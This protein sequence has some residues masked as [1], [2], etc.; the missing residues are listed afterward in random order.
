M[1]AE[2]SSGDR[3]EFGH[4]RR[5]GAS[6]RRH[7]WDV[8]GVARR[9]ERLRALAAETGADVFAADL[10]DQAQVDALRDHVAEPRLVHALVNVAGGAFGAA[11][12][13]ESDPADW[14]A[15][16]D[17]NVIAT[18]RMITAML[19]LLRNT[20]RDESQ[21]IQAIVTARSAVTLRT[22]TFSR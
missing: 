4:R 16:F 2:K 3:C 13:E 7:G 5:D 22:R 14:L 8:V 12:V 11:S 10:T 6:F 17:V 15:M 18:K 20:L 9:E 21:R 1:G 19:P